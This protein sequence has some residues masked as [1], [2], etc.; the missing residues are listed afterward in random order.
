MGYQHGSIRMSDA[1][2]TVDDLGTVDY[3]STWDHQAD[4]AR[5]RAEGNVDDTILLL[6]HPPTYTAGKRTQPEDLPTNGLPVVDVDR[7]GASPGTAPASWWPTRSSSSLTRLTSWTTSGVSRRPS[8][9]PA[10]RSAWTM[11]DACPDDP[12]SGYRPGYAMAPWSLPAR[13]LR[14]VSA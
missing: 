10:A 4:L 7:V 6:Q 13:S 2:L 1:P 5:R 8:W 9:R 12:V 14:W 3:L 11:S